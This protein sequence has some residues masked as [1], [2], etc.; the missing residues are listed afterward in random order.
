MEQPQH[1]LNLK[2]DDGVKLFSFFKSS[3]SWR[4]RLVLNLKKIPHEIVP[5]DLFKYENRTEAYR[6]INP[7]GYVPAIYIDNT[8]ITESMAI[9]EYLEE[10]R[11]GKK[12]FK[13]NS[14]KRWRIH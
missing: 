14:L 13:I 6:K 11:K 10:T 9:A 8:V 4:I 1:L 12:K 7:N 2:L 3:A 5:I